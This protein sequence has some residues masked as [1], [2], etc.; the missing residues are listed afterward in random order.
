MCNKDAKLSQ[1]RMDSL[2]TNGA[3]TTVYPENTRNLHLD[4]MPYTDYLKMGHRPE[5]KVNA[6]HSIQKQS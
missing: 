2:L 4:L 6:M 5:V 3:D 1:W